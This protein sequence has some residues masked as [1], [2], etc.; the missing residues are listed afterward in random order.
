M[1]R[2][3]GGGTFVSWVSWLLAGVGTGAGTGLVDGLILTRLV[4]SISL[5]RYVVMLT[6][7]QYALL[8][9]AA[10]LLI[11]LILAP[12]PGSRFRARPYAILVP[13]ALLVLIAP[14]GNRFFLPGETEPSSLAF[15]L[16][17]V[18]TLFGIGALLTR[19][20]RGMPGPRRPRLVAGVVSLLVLL[21][22]A[23]LFSRPERAP[24]AE[25]RI[26]RAG[27]DRAENLI[28]LLI[29]TLRNDH[30]SWNGYERETTPALDRLAGKGAVFT[31]LV[32]Q[33]PHTKASCAS[34]L[35]SL[36]PASH[37]AVENAGLPRS[38]V[39]LPEVMKAAGYR[40]F[41][42]SANTYI[43]PVFG[44]D[45]GFETLLT[46]PV[47]TTTR[48]EVGYLLRRIERR[49][50]PNRAAAWLLQRL[51]DFEKR[52]FWDVRPDAS[53][54]AAPD[55]IDPFLE[56]IGEGEEKEPFF[57][58]LHFLEPH[59]LYEAPE[60]FDT[61]FTGG[62]DGEPVTN[63]P[64]TAGLFSPVTLAPSLP[65]RERQNMIDRYDAEIV[66]LDTELARLFERLESTG[67]DGRTLLLVVA[68]HGEGFYEHGMWGHGHSLYDEELRVPLAMIH[69]ARI[70]ADRRI[71]SPV[72]MVDLM[73]TVLDLLGIPA[74]AGVQGRSLTGLL[75]GEAVEDLPCYSEI[76]WSGKQYDSLRKG[77]RKLI[78]EIGGASWLYDLASDP[79][80]TTDLSARD[81]GSAAAMLGEIE[82]IRSLFIESRIAREKDEES[83]ILDETT[84]DRLKALGY[85]E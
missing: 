47:L 28:I 27:G 65:E 15:D 25:G 78:R 1:N 54:L 71:D 68:D 61:L 22:G 50:G 40:T 2:N 19:I 51:T 63:H 20:G 41:G 85:I 3:G 43:S 46:L 79:G 33:A 70:E 17:L 38:A 48:N 66:Y 83:E 31:N 72:R 12:P 52:W 29:D 39:T 59:A 80:E 26:V 35:T 23:A 58:Y 69:P 64:S 49:F 56:W 8:G 44:F 36:H 9:V 74:P 24:E 37:T 53:Q 14:L 32:S 82:R 45:Q 73:P 4:T 77:D 67:L 57:A 76:E 55:V 13:L 18:L 11:R 30:V 60:P 84:R 75:Q 34:L 16:V 6:T 10:G 42:V 62:Y 7:L 5:P 21:C 81:P